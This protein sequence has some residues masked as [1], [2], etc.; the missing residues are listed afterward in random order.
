MFNSRITATALFAPVAIAF[1]ALAACG[2]KSPPSP[3]S[4]D[5]AVQA[6]ID[7]DAYLKAREEELARKEAELALKE[8][9]Q[10]LARREAGIKLRAAA[11]AKRSDTLH[12]DDRCGDAET[13]CNVRSSTQCRRALRFRRSCRRRSRRRPRASV[14][15]SPPIFRR[16]WSW[17]AR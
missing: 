3:S 17:T 15:A 8:R 16:T 5:P 10:D 2:K 14:I 6:E 9:E 1:L 11:V 4:D 13:C 12:H 7:K